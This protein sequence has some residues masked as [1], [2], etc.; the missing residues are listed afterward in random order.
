MS[1][2]VWKHEGIPSRDCLDCLA[3][4]EIRLTA[5]SKLDAMRDSFLGRS[6]N[7]MPTDLDELAPFAA[8][9][10]EEWESFLKSNPSAKEPIDMIYCHHITL[11]ALQ[12]VRRLVSSEL[13][14]NDVY[15]LAGKVAYVS[16]HYLSNY[17]EEEESRG[18]DAARHYEFGSPVTFEQLT[19]FA[20]WEEKLRE[21]GA[22]QFLD[23][24]FPLRFAM[25]PVCYDLVKKVIE[26]DRSMPLCFFLHVFF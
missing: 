13:D 4:K 12:H 19:R 6:N 14:L 24:R 5:E 7:V 1:S 20:D 17:E 25:K 26:G 11:Y 21:S 22:F 3:C 23:T 9:L 15:K 10:E 8:E 16:W 18:V 2:F